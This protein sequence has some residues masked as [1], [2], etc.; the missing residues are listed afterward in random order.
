MKII[1]GD[2]LEELDKLEENSIDCLLTDPPYGLAFM[3]KEWDSFKDNQAY[4]KW[5]EEWAKK[6][7]RV[8]K[9]GAFGLVF[10]GTRMVHRLTCG[11]EDAGFEIRDV[12]SWLYLCLSE[13]TKIL[14]TEGW[15][16][17]DEIKKQDVIF[18]FD[19]I[20]NEVYLDLVE[21]VFSYYFNGKMVNLENQYTDQL[22][23]PNHKVLCKY[24]I[25]KQ[26]STK[27]KKYTDDQY[28]YIDAWQ[29]KG[30]GC[31]LPLGAKYDGN[32]SIG[33]TLLAELIGWI[34]TEG[35]FQG[36]S[37][38][39]SQSKK[40]G[41]FR[42]RYLLGRLNIEYSEYERIRDKTIIQNGKEYFYPDY[43]EI[44]FYLKSS[45]ITKKIQSIIPNNKP[46]WHLLKIP[47]KEK[48]ALLNGLMGGDGSGEYGFFQS[49]K[50][51]LEWFQTFIHLMGYR[52]LINL[53]ETSVSFSKKGE[54]NLQEK[55][56]SV[57]KRHKS[58]EG[59]VWCIQTQGGNFFAK[60]NGKIFITGNSGFPKGTDLS[61]AIDRKLG[62]KPLY[63]PEKLAPDGK[64]YSARQIEGHTMT[65]ENVYGET[66]VNPI[67]WHV[68]I[69]QSDIAKAWYD[70]RTCLKPAREDVVLIQKPREGTFVDN[71]LKWGVGGINIGGSRIDINI[72]LETDNRIKDEA[73][74]IIRVLDTQDKGQVKFHKKIE[75]YMHNL[76]NLKGRYPTNVIIDEAIAD[77]LDTIYNT[78]DS[79]PKLK[80]NKDVN[81][82]IPERAVFNPENS[83]FFKKTS[84]TWNGVCTYP[85]A[86]SVSK[87]FYKTPTIK[88]V[89]SKENEKTYPF[90]GW[91]E[92]SME[93]YGLKDGG[94]ISKFFYVPKAST[95]EREVGL[96]DIEPRKRDNTRNAPCDVP[97][98]RNNPC[99]NFHPT[100]KPI[101]LL[102]Y[103]LRMIKPPTENPIVLDPFAGSGSTGIAARIENC[104]YILIE[105][106]E[107][108]MEILNKRM[109]ADLSEFENFTESPI[110]PEEHMNKKILDY[111]F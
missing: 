104:D 94:G 11:L 49:D 98:N 60:R 110:V 83:G 56:L 32:L 9:P 29:I 6:A 64:P 38:N 21:N 90:G 103:L 55:H 75:G 35:W 37:I 87:S 96:S 39:I 22:I 72:D 88:T 95:G 63:G 85:D 91:T 93:H 102:T 16:G 20:K 24:K 106:N 27:R 34:L 105:R 109:N 78:G 26:A 86:P 70:F 52:G 7:L 41:C 80:F 36:N 45:D 47:F 84:Q 73:K 43:K 107:L 92:R 100:V 44:Q 99:Y 33:G 74:N 62:F 1:N 67:K 46:A 65:T 58:Y 54:T 15:K 111:K 4:Q 31:I 12:I 17:K 66:V 3:G 57:D 5:T 53:N 51:F 2:S 81:R 19:Y 14:T 13:D 82:Q 30:D 76:F 61:R 25:R 23:T 50:F 69:P 28:R 40:E 8:L 97:Q 108:Y 18:G 89:Y 68:Q 71:I 77:L 101:K 48:K 79:T 59:L 10:C 42:I